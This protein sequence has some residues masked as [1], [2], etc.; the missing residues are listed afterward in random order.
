MTVSV[1]PGAVSVGGTVLGGGSGTG[2]G[3]REVVVGAVGDVV[4]PGC[5]VTGCGATTVSWLDPLAITSAMTR[6]STTRMATAARIHSHSRGSWSSGS[7][8]LGAPGGGGEPAPYWPVAF[9]SYP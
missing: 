4:K 7:G 3:T 9:G 2:R 8:G 6:P 1:G 5:G